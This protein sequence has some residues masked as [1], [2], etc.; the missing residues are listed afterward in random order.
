MVANICVLFHFSLK[1]LFSCP[2]LSSSPQYLC[3]DFSL[4]LLINV[5]K[6]FRE[7]REEKISKYL[8]EEELKHWAAIFLLSLGSYSVPCRVLLP[9][10][11]AAWVGMIKAGKIL[12]QPIY[13]HQGGLETAFEFIA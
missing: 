8:L 6:A 2:A 1:C 13:R 11:G 5:Y 3:I 12:G 7:P 9:G 10:C 4:C